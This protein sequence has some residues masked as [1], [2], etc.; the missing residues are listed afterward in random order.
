MVIMG[1]YITGMKGVGVEIITKT[2]KGGFET[3]RF[4]G[5]DLYP[6]Q[7]ADRINFPVAV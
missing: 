7:V 2:I 1:K 3:P 6:I 4:L 5:A